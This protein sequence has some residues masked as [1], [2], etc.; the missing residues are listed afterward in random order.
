MPR[1]RRDVLC[2]YA[3][4]AIT[5]PPGDNVNF[6]IDDEVDYDVDDITRFWNTCDAQTFPPFR[7][8]RTIYLLQN[9]RMMVEKNTPQVKS[10]LDL[11]W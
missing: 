1:A 4:S 10:D 3:A 5:P 11:P 2:V 7:C 6:N 9:E 8:S